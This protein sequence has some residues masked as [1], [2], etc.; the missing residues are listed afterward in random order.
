MSETSD[1]RAKRI[2]ADCE[3]LISR[4]TGSCDDWRMYVKGYGWLDSFDLRVIA[5]ELDRRNEANKQ[6]ECDGSV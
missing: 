6:I 3:W 4:L 2:I 5:D 1:E